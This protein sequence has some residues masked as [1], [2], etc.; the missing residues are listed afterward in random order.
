MKPL[1][2]ICIPT[3]NRAWCIEKQIIQ[4][5]QYPQDIWDKIEL[6][7]SDN[8]STD[9]TKEIVEKAMMEGFSCRYIRNKTNLG[10]DG[11]FSQCYQMAKGNY[12]WLLGDDDFI[13][14][15]GL[16]KVLNFI[17]NSKQEIG[18]VHYIPNNN[19]VKTIEYYNDSEKFLTDI[20]YHM[21]FISG[22]IINTK[23][24]STVDFA[25][26]NGTLISQV[27]LILN[28]VLSAKCNVLWGCEGLLDISKDFES[29]GGYNFFQVFVVNL[30]GIWNEYRKNEKIS[31]CLFQK[32]QKRLFSLVFVF[33]KRLLIHKD[34]GNFQTENGWKILFKYYGCKWYF[35]WAWVKYLW[36]VIKYKKR[37]KY[38]FIA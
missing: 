4:F 13:A 21:T 37:S 11:N 2:S 12:V 20:S 31:R 7:I 6:V 15:G 33:V 30:L 35:W 29:N 14:N 9:N 1:L 5:K 18:I 26:Y 22:S 23:Y 36:G 34:I 16:F 17:S 25:Y 28:A 32:L 38:E 8:C 10:M 27:P 24:V 19:F 3:Y